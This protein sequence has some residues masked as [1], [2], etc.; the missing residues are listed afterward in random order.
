[1]HTVMISAV[2]K[3]NHTPLYC[4][5]ESRA[6]PVPPGETMNASSDIEICSVTIEPK[7]QYRVNLRSLVP[8]P[9]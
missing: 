2:D 3:G 8:T 9:T 7:A 5:D 1:M 4:E 6:N